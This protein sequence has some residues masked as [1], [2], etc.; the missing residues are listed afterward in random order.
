ML[1]LDHLLNNWEF[2]ISAHHCRSYLVCKLIA[3]PFMEAIFG[4]FSASIPV[5]P[6]DP[7]KLRLKF[8]G[9]CHSL[10]IHFL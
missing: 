7:G 8:A 2:S 6:T 1:T 9:T 3:V 4:T 5:K 10:H